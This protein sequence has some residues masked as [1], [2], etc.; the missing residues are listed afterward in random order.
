[1][2]QCQMGK[3]TMGTP[4]HSWAHRADTKMFRIQ[5]PQAPLVQTAAQVR[6]IS[7]NISNKSAILFVAGRIWF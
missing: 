2:Y 3:Q 1:M 5:N 6:I 4:I 7:F